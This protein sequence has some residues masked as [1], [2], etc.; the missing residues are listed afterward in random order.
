MQPQPDR[1]DPSQCMPCP[2]KQPPPATFMATP[3]G[4]PTPQPTPTS[5]FMYMG[6]PSTTPFLST[7]GTSAASMSM[8]SMS[9]TPFSPVDS[10]DCTPTV[11]EASLQRG[12]MPPPPN[13]PLH[14]ERSA[15]QESDD[16]E[17]DDTESYNEMTADQ[18]FDASSV[19]QRHPSF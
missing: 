18:T 9:S 10:Q 4:G 16:D 14:M 17:V 8:S 12:T 11:P 13:L 3:F 5:K 6:S 1:N 19:S 7:Q 15:F 2:P